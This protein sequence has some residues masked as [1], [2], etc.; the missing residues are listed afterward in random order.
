MVHDPL[1]LWGLGWGPSSQQ[2]IECCGSMQNGEEPAFAIVQCWGDWFGFRLEP[3]AS[4]AVA[5]DVFQ[6]VLWV[7]SHYR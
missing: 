3:A 2:G 6:A 1:P 4:L 5:H 7:T